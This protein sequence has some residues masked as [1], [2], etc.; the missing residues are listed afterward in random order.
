MPAVR[1]QMHFHGNPS[2]LQRDKV[3]QRVVYVVQVVIFR[4]KQERRRRLAGDME[5]RVQSKIFVGGGRMRKRKLF[6]ALLASHSA[7]DSDRWPG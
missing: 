4:L 6:S 2:L 3:R 7:A 5:I 1:I